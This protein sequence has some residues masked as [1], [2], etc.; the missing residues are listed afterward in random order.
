LI[1]IDNFKLVNDTFGHDAGDSVLKQFADILANNIRAIDILSRWGGEEFVILCPH[2]E[3]SGALALAESLRIKIAEFE[4]DKVG[5]VSASFGVTQYQETQDQH[6][7]FV[8][9]DQTLYNSKMGGRNRVSF[10]V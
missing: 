8:Q 1:D 6:T 4:F 7:F 10:L 5:Y 3:L 2:T 9:V